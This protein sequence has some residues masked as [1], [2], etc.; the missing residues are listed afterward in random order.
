MRVLIVYAHPSEDSFT[1]N[2]RDSFIRGLESAGHSFVLSDLYKMNFRTDL[3]EEEYRREAYY[4]DD[5]P[6]PADVAAEQEKINASDAIVFISPLFWS[7]VPA[8][9]KGWF[10][11]VW[12]Y[13]FAYGE[14]AGK[15]AGSGGVVRTK[16][17]R[18]MKRLEKGLYI[19]SAGNTL[20]YFNRTGI[21]GAMKK[22]LL[23]D[24]LY[25]RVKSKDL[26]ILDGTSREMPGR[27]QSWAAHLEKAF[28]A[29]AGIAG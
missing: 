20:E 23:D 24:R 22:I 13:G 16:P 4:R 1:A 27:E 21:L 6:V 19:I 8:K 9:L 11:R 3:S 10:D 26:L 12:T 28:R 15:N 18:S 2:I 17:G 5:L 29:G 25:D 14:S 7:D